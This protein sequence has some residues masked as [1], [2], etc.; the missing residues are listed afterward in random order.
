MYKLVAAP[1]TKNTNVTSTIAQPPAPAHAP[2]RPP[3]GS[4]VLDTFRVR[5]HS[6]A[7]CPEWLE[8][9]LLARMDQLEVRL[10]VAECL[11][12]ALARAGLEGVTVACV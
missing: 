10:L 1:K 4:A 8:D 11:A 2:C 3:E 9:V 5:V 7:R 6:P 12:E